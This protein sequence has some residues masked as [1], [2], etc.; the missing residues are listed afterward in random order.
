MVTKDNISNLHNFNI[1]V[2]KDALRQTELRVNYTIDTK[3]RL[4]TKAITLLTIF[5]S[6]IT[7]FC[8]IMNSNL[9]LL[10]NL[11]KI[12]FCVSSIILGS[13]IFQLY[14]VLKS[15][16]NAAIGRYP[17]TWLYDESIIAG[18]STDNQKKDKEGF[19]IT[20]ILADY[21]T[22]ITIADNSNENKVNLINKAIKSGI[23]AIALLLVYP[24]LEVIFCLL[25][26]LQ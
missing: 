24:V 25:N 19:I 11:L 21:Q 17:S 10:T 14:K 26:H 3:K 1:P 2:L 8:T 23:L 6:F 22:S 20:H 18:N 5:I 15:T 4:D 7:L 13:G 12:L 9:I 16:N